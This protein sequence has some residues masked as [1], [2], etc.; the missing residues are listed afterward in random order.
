MKFHCMQLSKDHHPQH[1]LHKHDKINLKS[2]YSHMFYDTEK[3]HL[4][5]MHPCTWQEQ[6]I[7]QIPQTDGLG[8]K[9]V[10][11]S[12][13]VT[14]DRGGKK[15]TFLRRTCPPCFGS[16]MDTDKNRMKRPSDRQTGKI[17]PRVC[18]N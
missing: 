14:V 2:I 17:F 5:L 3:L 8:N 10:A 16:W 18:A 13:S 7:L 9:A 4:V 6:R 11:E 15:K 1:T 12:G